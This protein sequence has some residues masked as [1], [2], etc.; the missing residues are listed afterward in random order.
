[1][2]GRGLENTE[3][4]GILGTRGA[5]NQ[6]VSIQSLGFLQPRLGHKPQGVPVLRKFALRP[7]I[8]QVTSSFFQ[9]CHRWQRAWR[10]EQGDAGTPSGVRVEV[11]SSAARYS[12]Q[13]A[14]HMLL[15]V[16]RGLRNHM[17]QHLHF[18][19]EETEARRVMCLLC[20]SQTRAVVN[21]Q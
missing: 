7:G 14:R 8:L 20:P 11:G 1:M 2:L 9:M 5:C 12:E 18:T 6:L 10:E 15:G 17:I 19:H 13:T 4:D 16:R 21:S 3:G